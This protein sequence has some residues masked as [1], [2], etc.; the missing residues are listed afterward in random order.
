MAF[1]RGDRLRVDEAVLEEGIPQGTEADVLVT[2][3]CV[4]VTFHAQAENF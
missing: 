4:C 1:G 3:V 2:S